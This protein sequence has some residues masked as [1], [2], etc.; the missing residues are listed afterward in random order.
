M[1]QERDP[2]YRHSDLTSTLIDALKA[3]SKTDFTRYMGSGLIISIANLEGE[4][5]T[6]RFM[7]AGEDM[8]QIKHPIIASIKAHLV[9]RRIMRQS[10]IADID[11]VLLELEGK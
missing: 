5:L 9:L 8:E 6:S 2:E 4:Q 3:L 11:A 10:E 1:D 7:I